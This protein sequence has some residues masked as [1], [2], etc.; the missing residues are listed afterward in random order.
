MPDPAPDSP[1]ATP[2]ELTAA[3]YDS[4]MLRQGAVVN[5]TIAK[6]IE[7][8]ISNLWFLE[9][10][11]SAAASPELPNRL[12]LKWALKESVA[13]ERG[14]PEVVFYRELA[15]SL[16]SPPVVKCLATAPA[17]SRDRW[18]IIEDLRS[19]HANPPWPNRPADKLLYDAVAALA[20]VHAHWW[21]APSLGSTVGSLHTETALRTMVGG[22]RAH[23]PGFFDELAMIFRSRIVACTKKCSTHRFARG[24]GSWT[25]AH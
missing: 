13:P 21:E 3:L 25:N 15:L 1:P 23:L 10:V 5:V 6:Q 7:T 17:A 14:D 18:L 12:L 9:V 8:E 20:H 4:G 22:F 2:A 11:Y 19:S 24:F 16:L